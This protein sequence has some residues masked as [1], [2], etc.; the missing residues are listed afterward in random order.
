MRSGRSMRHRISQRIVH[1]NDHRSMRMRGGYTISTR[2]SLM[3]QQE[4]S[5]WI[6]RRDDH[7]TRAEERDWLV[8]ASCID[9]D[10]IRLQ[11][12]SYRDWRQTR[13]L[14]PPLIPLPLLLPP[15]L[16]LLLWRSL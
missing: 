2:E 15:P 12:P 10:P 8:E 16:P 14:I 6:Q 9:G 3:Q 1:S 11:T 5:D 7:S 4:R 13:L